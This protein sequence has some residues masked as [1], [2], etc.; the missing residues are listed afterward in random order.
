MS[1]IFEFFNTKK[2][3]Y[4]DIKVSGKQLKIGKSLIN[5]AKKQ[6]HIINNKYLLWIKMLLIR[7]QYIQNN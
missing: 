2:E 5:Y 4:M 1:A 6:L 3:N 7:N